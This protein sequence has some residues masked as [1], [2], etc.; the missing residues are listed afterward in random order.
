MLGS[1]CKFRL[2]LAERFDTQSHHKS[3]AGR[4]IKTLSV[5]ESERKVKSLSHVQL[6]A[7]PWIA[8]YQAPPSMGFSREEYWSGVPLPSPLPISEWQ[9]TIKLHLVAGSILASELIYFNCT[10]GCRFQVRV[11]HLF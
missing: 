9:V 3:I 8:A 7:T 6:L 4:H 2:S 11:Q 1:Y 10:S 5:S